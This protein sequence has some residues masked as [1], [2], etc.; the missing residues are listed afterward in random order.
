MSNGGNSIQRETVFF[1]IMKNFIWRNEKNGSSFFLLQTKQ[2]LFLENMY[3]KKEVKKTNGEDVVWYTMSCDGT[4]CTVPYFPRETPVM[5]KGYFNQN[6]NAGYS[7]NLV[8]SEIRE[9]SMDDTTTIEYLASETFPGVSY[10]DAVKIVGNFGADIF[11]FVKDDVNA[12]KK[13]VQAT[14]LPEQ[15]VERMVKL[16][17]VTTAERELFKFLNPLGISYSVAAKAIK[18]YGANAFNVLKKATYRA[19]KRL[20]LSFADCDK[21]AKEFGYYF[22]DERRLERAVS[23]A[24]EALASC[25]HVWFEQKDFYDNVNRILYTETFKETVPRSVLVMNTKK[26]L[27]GFTKDGIQC[28]YNIDLFKAEEE[29]ANHIRRL[30]LNAE[31]CPYYPELL[32]IA[33][34]AC[35]MK[36]GKQQSEAFPNLLAS[37][38]VKILTGGPG[39]GKTT[40]LKGLLIAYLTMY[41]ETKVCLV[42]PTG[43]AAQRMSE[44]TEMPAVTIHRA[45]NIRPYGIDEIS[46]KDASNPLDADL[47]VCDEVSMCSVEIARILLGAV[48]TG[49]SVWFIGDVHQLES[50]GAGAVLHDCLKASGDLIARTMLTEVFRQKGGSPII[51]NANR[52]NNGDT[53][54]QWCDDFQYFH[55]KNEEETLEIIKQLSK[56]HFDPEN[57]F[58]CQILCPARKGLSG[59]DN[60]NIVLQEMLNPA[61][62][63][64]YL[65]YGQTKFRVGDKIIM[66]NNN[67][68]ENCL[69]FN[70]DIGVIKRIEQKGLVVDIRGAELLLE[71]SSLDD[72]RLSYGMTIHKSQGSEFPV[73]ICVMPMNPSNMLVRNLLYTAVTRAKK[74]VYIINEGS[75]M[76]TAIKVDKSGS[77]QTTL[78]DRLQH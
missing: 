74:K 43:R 33:S 9:S 42:A 32:D 1:G 36:F 19:G 50:V 23:E 25:G 41:P 67:Y 66:T 59:I 22:T 3:S 64:Q 77:R 78:G 7:W 72:I 54:L 71:R 5:V 21:I 49:A 61:K 51:E 55:T 38:G 70:G 40:T 75:A 12:I 52:I 73:V 14:D 15:C 26:Y 30:S 20:G 65:S 17:K 16:I 48:K 37:K 76:E 31:K 44:S 24:C 47:I 27:T 4:K 46:H 34:K 58:S 6:G 68:D 8:I 39:T 56:E 63:G 28:F 29:I 45:C 18:F 10:G 69:Y 2:P 35:G 53:N 62:K 13:I 11:S 57:P 60:C